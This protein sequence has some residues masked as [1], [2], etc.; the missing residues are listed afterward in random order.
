VT[1][2]VASGVPEPIAT[3]ITGHT[4]SFVFRRYNVRRDDVQ[5]D[6]GAEVAERGDALARQ[7][8]YLAHQ[9]GTTA[10]P[11]PLRGAETFRAR[12]PAMLPSCQ[13]VGSMIPS[14]VARLAE[15]ERGDLNPHG[16]YPTGS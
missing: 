3:T 10:T 5:A 12:Q 9:R 14:L 1:N 16:C 4:D 7:A 2:L 8:A 6:G 11:T 13:T 15:C